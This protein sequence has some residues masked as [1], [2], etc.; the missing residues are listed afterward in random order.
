MAMPTRITFPYQRKNCPDA[1]CPST[2][3]CELCHAISLK[4]PVRA[5][6]VMQACRE[7]QFET[8]NISRPLSTWLFGE[9]PHAQHESSSND[10]QQEEISP[11]LVYRKGMVRITSWFNA[12]SDMI[13]FDADS[14]KRFS[15]FFGPPNRDDVF[16]AALDPNINLI[17]S[18]EFF[19]KW[20]SPDYVY[21]SLRN[22]LQAL[23]HWYL[24]PRKH[25]Y[26]GIGGL[27]PFIQT[28]DGHQKAIHEGLFSGDDEEIRLLP[29][30]DEVLIKKYE[31]L[32]HHCHEHTMPDFVHGLDD[33]LLSGKPNLWQ[34]RKQT[35]YKRFSRWEDEV[36]Y[37]WIENRI[38]PPRENLG[39]AVLFMLQ[40]AD[41]LMWDQGLGIDKGEEIM[42]LNGHLKKDHP[43]VQKYQFSLP[44]FTPVFAF[45]KF[46][47]HRATAVSCSTGQY[48]YPRHGVSI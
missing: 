32:R 6:G 3:R 41:F 30:N 4:P 35:K 38:H 31:A 39:D 46:K 23:Y 7:A 44:D 27:P 13:Q 9:C 34:N 10:V 25:I 11:Y 36:Y 18:V 17:F 40:I 22:G 12:A 45:E 26:I 2:P 47:Y 1:R 42:D 43:L 33:M 16:Q 14:I 5:P 48:T 19:D 37:H 21:L 28:E 24:K 15:M 20:M 8:R 29:P